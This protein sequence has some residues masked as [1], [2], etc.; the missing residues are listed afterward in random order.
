MVCSCRYFSVVTQVKSWLNGLWLHFSILC[1]STE[2]K[3][4]ISFLHNVKLLHETFLVL[5]KEYMNSFTSLLHTGCSKSFNFLDIPF[6]I[7]FSLLGNWKCPQ[8]YYQC[9]DGSCINQT[10]V[11]NGN[12]DCKNTWDDEDN[13]SKCI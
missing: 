1:T 3:D 5:L 13:C 11:C 6:I 8:E 4:S 9:H 12:L 10:L 2:I 7:W